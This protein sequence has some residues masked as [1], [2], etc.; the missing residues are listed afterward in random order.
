VEVVAKLLAGDESGVDGRRFRLAPGT[1]LAYRRERARVPLTIGSW[2]RQ[3]IAWAGTAAD[4]VKV[5]GTANPDLVPLVRS[6]LGDGSRTRLV[7][8]CVSVVDDDGDWARERARAAV[9]PYLDVVAQHDPTLALGPDEEPP[10]ERFTIAGTPEE[11]AARVRELWSAGADR[12]ELG[13][14]QGRTTPS[15]IDLLCERVLPLLRDG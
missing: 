8:G 6:W 13:T 14:P 7:V 2:G 15:G 3:T 11:V 9:G 10:L 1:T 5:G 12:V 4:E